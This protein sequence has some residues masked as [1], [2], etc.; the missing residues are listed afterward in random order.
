MTDMRFMHQVKSASLKNGKRIIHEEGIYEGT[1]GLTIKYFHSENDDMYRITI[2]KQEGDNYI[3]RTYHNGEKIE[4]EMPLEEL[5]GQLEGDE[6]FQFIVD[7]L[8][9][10]KSGG[11]HRRNTYQNNRRNSRRNSRTRRQNS[12]NSRNNSNR[13]R[14]SRNSRTRRSSTRRRLSR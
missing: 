11:A 7:F 13:N 6:R 14:N 4:T 2:I 10:N 8:K 5:I 3:Y 12:R 1:K 9:Q